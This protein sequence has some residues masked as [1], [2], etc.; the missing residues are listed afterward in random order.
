MIMSYFLLPTERSNIFWE[1]WNFFVVTL[2]LYE[3]D[4]WCRILYMFVLELA[5]CHLNI[6]VNLVGFSSGYLCWFWNLFCCLIVI[7]S[8]NYIRLGSFL[9]HV[10]NSSRLLYLYFLFEYYLMGLM[11]VKYLW[12]QMNCQIDLLNLSGVELLWPY[13]LPAHSYVFGA[14]SSA[15]TAFI[16][17]IL[18]VLV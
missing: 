5:F 9:I 17:W 16:M 7:Q 8:L 4:H 18:L 1:C 2:V 15:K 3:D 13:S 10:P 12:R 14:S 6:P 11:Q